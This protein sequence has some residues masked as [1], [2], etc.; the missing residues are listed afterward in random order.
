[1]GAGVRQRYHLQHHHRPPGRTPVF[2]EKAPYA[3]ALIDL[4][5]GPRMMANITGDGALDAK[6]DDAV[7]VCFEPRGNTKVPQFRR[8]K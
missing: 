4:A 2:R 3:V 7:E 1:M 8:V 6:I 5:E